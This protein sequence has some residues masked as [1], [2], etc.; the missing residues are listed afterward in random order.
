VETP[1][2]FRGQRIVG[3]NVALDLLNTQNGPAG[4]PPEDDVLG[5]YGDLLAWASHIGLLFAAEERRLKRR[6]REHPAAADAALRRTR[7]TRS[8]L[9]ELFD[10]V[11]HGRAP[12]RE[13]L[14][15]LQ[16]DASEAFAHGRLVE[17]G[18]G[19]RWDWSDDEDLERPLWPIIDAALTLVTDGPLDR[20]KGCASC[21][22]LFVDESKN[23]SR[24]WCSME[25]CGAEDKMRKY[26]ARRASARAARADSAG[27]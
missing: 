9:H 18:E 19:Y 13:D 12:A 3:G 25:D 27:G 15:R 14:R 20:V 4:E 7:A 23:R 10:A 2:P 8:S 24:R 26:V 16:Q 21:R 22:F 11:A 17:A 6:A 5:D 1:E